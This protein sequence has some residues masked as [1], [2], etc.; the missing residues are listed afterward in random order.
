MNTLVEFVTHTKGIEYLIAIGFLALY[1]LFV[2]FLKPAPI[3]GLLRSVRD[4]ARHIKANGKADI[5]KLMKNTVRLPFVAGAY[6]AALPAYFAVG[7]M[8]KTE[9]ML[10]RTVGGGSMAWRP[11]EAYLAGRANKRSARRVR[12][13]GKGEAGK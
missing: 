1:A 3:A 5:S 4:D 9:E 12:K 2:E 11:L 7:V 8:L 6:L 10:S 13:S